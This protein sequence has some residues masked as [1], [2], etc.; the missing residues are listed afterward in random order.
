MAKSILNKKNLF[1]ILVLIFGIFYIFNFVFSYKDISLASGGT[2]EDFI[3]EYNAGRNFALKGFVKLFFLPDYSTDFEK[4]SQPIFYTHNPSLP[5]AVQGF[6]IKIGFNV[7]QSRI[8]YSLI[9]LS[10]VAFLFLF[11]SESVSLPA[12]VFSSIFLIVNFSG[13]LSLVDHNQY[14]LSFPILFGYLWV[15]YGNMPKRYFIVPLIFFIASFANYMLAGFMLI[16]ELLFGIFEKNMRLFFFCFL[17]VSVGAIIHIMQ[18]MSA[19]TPSIALQDIWLTAQ[20][21]FFSIPPRKELLNFYQA[22]NMVLWGSNERAPM[23]SYLL[24]AIR[25]FYLFKIPLAVG[26]IFT[27]IL[28]IFRR[29][30]I[31]KNRKFI[32]PLFLAVFI[33]QIVF[34][35]TIGNHPLFFYAFLVIFL[36]MAVGDLFYGLIEKIKPDKDFYIFLLKNFIF[37]IIMLLAIVIIGWKYFIWAGNF[38]NDKKLSDILAMLENYRNK[39]FFTNITPNTVSFKTDAWS[40][41]SCLPEGL[42]N[43]DASNCYSKFSGAGNAELV[44]NYI[45]LSSYAYAFK[46][47]RECFLGLKAKLSLKYELVEETADGENVVYKV[48]K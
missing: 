1:L 29:G 15:R 44:P 12:A 28:Y 17:S 41:G 18:N 10:G 20:N 37:K 43:I 42:L 14:S 16:S 5:S 25:P 24:G 9:S 8:F 3:L 31:Y 36:G 6:L 23:V 30:C 46:C 4:N 26:G 47:S 13:F 27:F 33:W 7:F 19:L 40:I 48:E 35:P 38:S 45:F 39:T 32:I 22:H 21:R 2:Q 34:L 11:L